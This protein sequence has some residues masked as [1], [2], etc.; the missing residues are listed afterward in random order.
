MTPEKK[1][2]AY[3]V[4]TNVSYNAIGCVYKKVSGV[5]RVAKQIVTSEYIWDNI[6]LKGGAYGGGCGFLNGNYFLYVLIS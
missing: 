5:L 1:N 3:S 6:R 4:N 2:I